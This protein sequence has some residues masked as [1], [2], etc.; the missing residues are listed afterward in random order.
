MIFFDRNLL[1]MCYFLSNISLVFCDLGIEFKAFVNIW[2]SLI[3][4]AVQTC[5]KKSKVQA[6]VMNAVRRGP[7]EWSFV[8]NCD[9]KMFQ[10]AMTAKLL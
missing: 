8:L 1:K 9:R 7:F 10:L 5:Y 3:T 2:S 4:L 6:C